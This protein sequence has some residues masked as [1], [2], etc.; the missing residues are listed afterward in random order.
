MP[1]AAGG[2]RIWLGHKAAGRSPAVLLQR[3]GEITGLELLLHTCCGPCSIHST[4]QLLAE[5]CQPVLFF[6]NPNIHPYGEYEARREG[7]AEVARLR[8]LPLLIEPAYDPEEYFRLVSFHEQERCRYCYEL[9]LGRAAAKARELG[10]ARFGT[11]LLI[12]PYQ[13]RELLLALG[14]RLADRHGL[15]FHEA[16]WRPGFRASQA[17]ARELGIYR[18]KYCGC[19]YSERERFCRPKP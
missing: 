17:K 2:S 8:G 12:S 13:D 6:A 1:A 3:N 11:T 10:L 16:D 7:L 9:R 14:R 4:E 19:L 15:T 5:G 18:Q